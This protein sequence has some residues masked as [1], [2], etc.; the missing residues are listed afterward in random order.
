MNKEDILTVYRTLLLFASLNEAD[1]KFFTSHMHDY[2]LASPR[3]RR[4]L[5]K[6]WQTHRP[7]TE[8]ADT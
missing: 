2:L 6:A 5:V 1:A 4:A 7:T 3:A 8:R